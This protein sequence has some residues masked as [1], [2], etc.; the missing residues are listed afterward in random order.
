MA[1]TGDIALMAHLMRRAGFDAGRDE[2]EAR[3]AR[4]YDATVE[5]LLYRDRSENTWAGRGASPSLTRLTSCC[6]SKSMP[7]DARSSRKAD[8]GG[9]LKSAYLTQPGRV[10][11]Q[12]G[13]LWLAGE[14]DVVPVAEHKHLRRTPND[15][16]QIYHGPHA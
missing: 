15:A 10:S 6:L 4:G 7:Y 11:R 3:V 5:E 8:I 14:H 13:H 16:F 9:R 12:S 2:L 1:H